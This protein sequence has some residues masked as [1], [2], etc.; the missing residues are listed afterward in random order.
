MPKP[1]SPDDHTDRSHR[2]ARPASHFGPAVHETPPVLPE[3]GPRATWPRAVTLVCGAPVDHALHVRQLGQLALALRARGVER[4]TLRLDSHLPEHDDRHVFGH[5]PFEQ[6]TRVT[7]RSGVR[8]GLG[9]AGEPIVWWHHDPP[10]AAVPARLHV[11]PTFA[12]GPAEGAVAR[13]ERAFQVAATRASLRPPGPGP[14]IRRS[15][16]RRIVFHQA[17]FHVGDMLWATPLLD[18]LGR[19]VPQ[20][21][22]T[23]VGPPGAAPL[24]EGAPGVDR[25]LAFDE[26]DDAIARTRVLA[27]LDQGGPI[28][29]ALLA[30]ARWPTS[31]WLGDALAS[32]GVG[33]RINLEYVD[34]AYD[35]D[36]PWSGATH[37]RWCLWN[38]LPS[39][40]MLLE[41]LGC[42][43]HDRSA[44]DAIDPTPRLLRSPEVRRACEERLATCG[45][46]APYA[47]LAPGGRSSA[48][49]PADRFAALGCSLLARRVRTLLIAGAPGERRLLEQVATSIDQPERVLVARDPLPV[50]VEQLA[51]ATLLVANDS[52]PIHLATAVGTPTLYFAQ[53]EKLVHAHPGGEGSTVALFDDRANDPRS[54][55][56]EQA[57]RALARIPSHAAGGPATV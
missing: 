14:A 2:M 24:I 4:L 30:F 49:W 27:A 42:L 3:A 29:L 1:T 32:R 10:P 41:L 28:D 7:E 37:E 56:V 18:A 55:T 11:R 54:I 38:G 35:R 31:R 13:A 21:H 40:R 12:L 57:R 51:G 36:G 33:H 9:A 26:R 45:V 5:L 39:P 19:W 6:V 43:G 16:L 50:F 15:E 25:Y 52:A 53:Q 23:V 20:A 44:V 8:R 17:R 22:V 48:R 47:V 34:P 46:E